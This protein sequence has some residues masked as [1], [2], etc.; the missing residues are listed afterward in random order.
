MSDSISDNSVFAFSK[1]HRLQWEPTQEKHV[2]LY[3]EGMVELNPTS[4]AIL[5]LCDGERNFVEI[6]STLEDKF[7]ASGIRDDVANFL[8]TALEKNWVQLQA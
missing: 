4:A 8:A 1:L 3:P 5:E 7:S 6:V 2:I